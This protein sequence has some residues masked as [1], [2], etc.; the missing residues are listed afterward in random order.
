MCTNVTLARYS[1]EHNGANVVSLGSSLIDAG[2]AKAIVD[3]FL[4]TPTSEARYLRRLLKVRRLEEN[5]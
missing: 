3:M 4:T 1:R 2:E 5:F